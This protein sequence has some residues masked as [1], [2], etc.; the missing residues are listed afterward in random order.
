MVES[1]G[2]VQKTTISPQEFRCIFNVKQ[3]KIKAMLDI[4]I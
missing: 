3:S 1:S 2:T 4:Y